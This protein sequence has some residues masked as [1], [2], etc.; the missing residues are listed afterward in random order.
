MNKRSP[1]SL[2]VPSQQN[3]RAILACY[4]LPLTYFEQ[5]TH[6]IENLTLFVWSQENKYVLR[7]YPQKKKSDADI[8]LEL[9]FM[10]HL[11]EH[12]LPTPAIIPSSDKRLLVICE[13]EQQKW[14]CV[15]MEYAPGARPELFT[16]ALLDH[17]ACL[18][19]HMHMLGEQYAKTQNITGGR[20]T[21]RETTAM[22]ELRNNRALESNVRDFLERVRV[23][24]VPLDA[25]LPKGL[26]H[27][28]FDIDNVF[29]QDNRVT[30]IL[31]FGD[32]EYMPL[33][34][35]LGYTLWDVLLE[36]GGSSAAVARYVQ[37]Y[38]K[39]RQLSQRE[40][41]V[42]REIMLFRHYVITTVR[43]HFGDFSQQDL[44]KALQQ[45]Q[46]IR[47]FDLSF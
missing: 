1:E 31:D 37:Q 10:S 11:R 18:Q 17:M 41:E 22:D 14:Q 30:A 45:E 27:F 38:Q 12:G 40:K 2:F 6:G 19:A 3:V 39:V 36:T 25:S 43:I 4:N 42:L 29:T 46:E 28:D 32:R 9:E 33:I 16:S 26:S 44:D 47:S 8:L 13:L 15:L 23:F 34:V 7:V 21:L 35:C 5:A 24:A 20:T